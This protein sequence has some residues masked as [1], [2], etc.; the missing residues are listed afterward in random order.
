VQTLAEIL[1]EENWKSLHP[2]TR[3][4]VKI[5]QHIRSKI[6][7]AAEVRASLDDEEILVTTYKSEIRITRNEISFKRKSGDTIR[8]QREKINIPDEAYKAVKQEI[9]NILEHNTEPNYSFI[10]ETLEKHFRGRECHATC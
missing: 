1:R 3:L 7:D 8:V 4:V 2:A 6:D 9:Q 10:I 5:L